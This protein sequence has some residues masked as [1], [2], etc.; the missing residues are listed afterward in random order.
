MQCSKDLD[1]KKRN[2]ETREGIWSS[3]LRSSL[4]WHFPS[5]YMTEVTPLNLLSLNIWITQSCY[6]QLHQLR[7]VS[8]LSSLSL[9]LSLTHTHTH[10]QT[11]TLSLSTKVVVLAHAFVASHLDDCQ[12]TTLR[13]KDLPKVPMCGPQICYRIAA[14]VSRCTLCCAPSYLRDC[15]SL[16]PTV[17]QC[18]AL[19]ASLCDKG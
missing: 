12:A 9:S 13:V 14:Q 19:G 10:T 3:L 6:Y 18:N 15:W 11:G 4:R 17:R 7:V 1:N 2:E 5:V 16:S 8:L